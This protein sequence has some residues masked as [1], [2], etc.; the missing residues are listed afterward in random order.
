MKFKENATINTSDF[1]N[2]LFDGYI[3]LEEL[4][5]NEK[6]IEEVKNAIKVLKTFYFQSINQNV[7]EED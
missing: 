5:E 7:L 6:D 3:N 2:D 1:W 4:L